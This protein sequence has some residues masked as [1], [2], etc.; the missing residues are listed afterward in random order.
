[1]KS[2]NIGEGDNGFVMNLPTSLKEITED[3][4]L[5]VTSKIRIAP[6]HVIVALVYRCKLPEII[7]T[8]KKKKDLATAIV[9]L[10]VSCSVPEDA[11]KETVEMFNSMSCGDKLIIAG[12]DIERGHHLVCP[13][14]FIT[15]DR[16]IQI[17]NSDM[18]FAKGVMIDQ[19]YYY[20]IDFKLVPIT[21]IKGYYE[22][23]SEV[24]FINPFLITDTTEVA[25]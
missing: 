3:Y 4:L 5:G 1:M 12:T 10:F 23:N 9:P 16:I 17:Y 8:A 2:F 24:N 22:R 13:K 21:D 19:N 15:I 20:F 25:N 7:S 6:Y 18:N 14:N 11:G